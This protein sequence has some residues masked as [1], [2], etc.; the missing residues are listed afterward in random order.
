MRG[1]REGTVNIWK[2]V[3]K[4][5][6]RLATYWTPVLQVRAGTVSTLLGLCLVPLVVVSGE[7]PLIYLM[8]A[9][10]LILGGMGILVTAV[11]AVKEDDTLEEEDLLPE[12]ES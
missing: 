7:P 9:G 3:D 8:S 11:L 1:D 12:E 5:G 4:L 2:P 6:F 10:A